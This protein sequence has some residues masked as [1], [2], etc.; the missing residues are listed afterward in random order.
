MV[1]TPVLRFVHKST[2]LHKVLAGIHGWWKYQDS[3]A[4]NGCVTASQVSC[5]PQYTNYNLKYR[6]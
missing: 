6:V 4:E 2:F 5:G 3:V 1:H